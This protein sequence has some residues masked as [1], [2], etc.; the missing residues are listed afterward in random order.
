MKIAILKTG[1]PPP[2]L[3]ARFGG[4][5]EMIVAMIGTGER[6]GRHG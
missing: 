3:E 2:E 4:Y 1:A 5:P 6:G